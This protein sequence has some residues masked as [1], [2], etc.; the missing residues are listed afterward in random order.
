MKFTRREAIKLG[1]VGGGSL[2]VPWGWAEP[3]LAQFSPQ[4]PRF[5]QPF[6][7]PP[8]L[9]PV[10]SDATTDYYEIKVK[11]ALAQILPA[12][13]PQTKIWS[14]N[15]ITPGY[16]IRQAGGKESEGGRLSRVRFINELGK[17]KEGRD[18]RTVTH[19]HGM[20]SQPYYDGHAEDYIPTGY[21]KDYIYPNDR[22]ATLW[23]HDHALDFTSRNVYMG[24]AGMYI[25]EDVVERNLPLPKGEYDIPLILQDK[26]FATDGSLVFNNL[27]Q[28]S[29]YGDVMLVNGVPWPRLEVA[30]R[31]YRFRIVNA[32]ASRNYGL[33]LSR[34]A[35]R[36]SLG[37]ELIVI[38]SDG[39]LLGE[40]VTLKAPLQ[41]LPVAMAERY[42]VIIDFSRY[43][44]GSKVYLRNVGFT[45]TIDTD[46]RS[47]ALM[48]FDVVREEKDDSAIPPVLRPVQRID[49]AEAVRT[50]TF[51]FERNSGLW[52]IN[53]K[54]WNKNRVDANPAEGDVEIWNLVNPG[55][56]WV[57][58]VHI[59]LVD[60]QI[61]DRNGMPPRPYE[62]GW[63]DVFLVGEFQT[64]RVIMRFGTRGGDYIKGKFMMHCHNL[65]HEDHSMMTLFEVGKGGLDPITT[66]PAK[67]IAECLPL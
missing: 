45:G 3:A 11:K 54:T 59:H 48:L 23:Y 38:G 58:P 55:S 29:I 25:V 37:D 61:L 24:L 63:K 19:L 15:G 20:A 60:S 33:M 34:E 9:T 16:T 36:Q 18:I 47:H 42:E 30:N 65:V 32:S 52:K 39:G 57:H 4:I 67:P 10:R 50:R 1:A 2:L 13:Y 49:P 56:G 43:P 66:A 40:P 26:Q 44:V 8:T 64:V 62:A 51:R 31:K 21:C 46:A 35:E 28:R 14:Y 53:N 6:H 5:E 12:P 27:A 17:D 41:S 22:A 7:I